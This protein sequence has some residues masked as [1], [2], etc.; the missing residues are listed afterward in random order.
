[1]RGL[2]A[3][4]ELDQE[5]HTTSLAPLRTASQSIT[6]GSALVSWFVVRIELYGETR[7][8]MSTCVKHL[9]AGSRA[10]H[11]YPSMMPGSINGILVVCGS[12]RS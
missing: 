12:V 4:A 11:S 1:M 10:C 2:L 8:H 3:G 9:P 5:G 6:Y 7:Q